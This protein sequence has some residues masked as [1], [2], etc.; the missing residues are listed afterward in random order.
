[1]THEETIERVCA[2]L[3]NRTKE[4]ALTVAELS[5]ELGLPYTHVD[6]AVLA[7]A[8]QGLI[9]QGTVTSRG[10]GPTSLYRTFYMKE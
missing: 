5:L 3:A 1:M 6:L 9:F 7:L 2:A 10:D 8:N 4:N